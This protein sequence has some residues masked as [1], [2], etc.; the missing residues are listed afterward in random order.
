MK[1]CFQILFFF[2]IC[3]VKAQNVDSLSSFNSTYDS[4][5]TSDSE[6][7]NV[8]FYKHKSDVLINNAGP[9]GSP[10]Y[11]PSG[12]FLY[13]KT[14]IKHPNPFHRKLFK[15][16][17]IKP[18]TNITYINASRKEQQFSIKH[19]QKFGKLMFFNFDFIK[20]S[21]PGIYVNQEVNTTTFTGEFRFK[22]RNN[23]YE[24]SISNGIYRNFYQENGGLD[25]IKD[26]ENQL[27]NNERIYAV[28]LVTS[29]SF[30]KTYDNRLEQRLDLFKIT[31]DTTSNKIVY[32]KH[33]LNYY[34]KQRVFF[35]NDPQSYIYNNTYFDTISSVDSIY[36]NNLSNRGS[37]GLRSDNWNLELFAQNDRIKYSQFYGID[38]TFQNLYVGLS[39]AVQQKS[40]MVKFLSKYGL[41]GY[42]KGDI[43]S[44]VFI[45]YDKNKY[46]ITGGV[47][48]NLEEPELKFVNYTSN[49]FYWRNDNFEK[50]SI[51]DFEINFKLKKL[52]LEVFA[53]N[54]I[55]NNTLYYDSLS[56]VNQ[57]KKPIS[58]STFSLAKN[59]RLWNLHFRTAF[60]YQITSNDSIVPLPNIIARQLFYYQKPIFKGALKIQ[61]GVG[62]S[63][64]TE[65][66]GYAYMPA[67]T[68]FYI[69]RNTRIGFYPNIDLFLNAHLKRAQIFLKYEHI[70]AG[71]SLNKSYLIPDYPTLNKSLKF[72]V[73]WNMFD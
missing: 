41:D 44:E 67:L 39:G 11:Y 43:A 36:T 21:S 50:Q 18:F 45:S 58:I 59:Y 34:A 37:I 35:D 27:F 16:E 51:L 10:Y 4:L 61:F 64:S 57:D 55:L 48:Y 14:L 6:S 8:L 65:Y 47:K 42:R 22:T 13:E 69:Q 73:S 32:L 49:H 7:M 28:K 70:N 29:N 20:T 52:Q 5:L 24:V 68:E 12:R 46:I 31:S 72:G 56:L 38:T 23:N 63:Y 71:R 62:I 19:L 9:F 33:R 26:F 3:T 54:K 2:L 15:L 1:I 53:E 25:S 40:L 66:Y 30:I 60:I 17:G